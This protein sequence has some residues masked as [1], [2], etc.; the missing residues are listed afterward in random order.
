MAPLTEKSSLSGMLVLSYSKD[1]ERRLL[2]AGEGALLVALGVVVAV[3]GEG[4]GGEGRDGEDSVGE[5]HLGDG[6]VVVSS[7]DVGDG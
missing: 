3:S 5:T 2:T 1:N 4:D 6:V 7:V